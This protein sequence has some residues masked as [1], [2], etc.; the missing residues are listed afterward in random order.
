MPVAPTTFSMNCFC[1]EANSFISLSCLCFA[2]CRLHT[3]HSQLDRHCFRNP[4]KVKIKAKNAVISTH[5]PMM[6]LVIHNPNP[7]LLNS[8]L[9]HA[10]S[11][12]WTTS[13]PV[14]NLVLIVQTAFH[15]QCG[16]PTF[17]NHIKLSRL[18][19]C[20]GC[21][22]GWLAPF[23]STAISD[24]RNH[25]LEDVLGLKHC[26]SGLQV[27]AL[28]TAMP[29]CKTKQTNTRLTALFQY[30]PGEPVPER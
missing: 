6:A 23:L 2:L 15:L 27:L 7:D 16:Q 5:R 10:E 12:Q 18:V 4:D 28:C 20:S 29:I 24:L 1:L 30:Y 9:M 11:L 26:D 8:R 17:S 19:T 14:P 21:Y 13:L 22:A 25:G 3:Q